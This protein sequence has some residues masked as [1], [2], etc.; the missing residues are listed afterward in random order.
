MKIEFGLV[1]ENGL[2]YGPE[3][4]LH[5][6]LG[7]GLDTFSKVQT[8]PTCARSHHHIIYMVFQKYSRHSHEVL[9][10]ILKCL[11]YSL[12][13]SQVASC[14]SVDLYFFNAVKLFFNLP[15]MPS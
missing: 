2:F 6:G 3:I 11:S 1:A 4:S 15:S 12:E 13:G 14:L 9:S 7:V 10:V 5:T 8:N